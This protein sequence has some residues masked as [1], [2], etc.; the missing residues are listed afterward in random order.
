MSM[1]VR[2]EVQPTD[3]ASEISSTDPILDQDIIRHLLNGNRSE[4]IV[5]LFYVVFAEKHWLENH[6]LIF[7]YENRESKKLTCS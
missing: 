1:D 6:E 5:Q 4:D 3:A 7:I 2:P